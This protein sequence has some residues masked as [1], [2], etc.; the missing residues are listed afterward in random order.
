MVEAARIAQQ[1]A[2][3]TTYDDFLTDRV[4]QLAMERTVQ[5]I[6]EAARRV[7]TTFKQAH[8][9][10]PWAALVAQ[11]NVIVH[12]YYGIDYGLIWRVAAIEAPLLIER[13]EPL[14]PPLDDC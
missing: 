14:L 8:P 3:Q 4:K 2:L 5:I 1:I 11:R 6:G 7:S 13:L 9:E 10:I 12:Q